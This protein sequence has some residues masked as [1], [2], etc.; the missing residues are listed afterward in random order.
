[1]PKLLNV[2]V[3]GFSGAKFNENVA[4]ALIAIALDVVEE[5]NEAD[6]Y[7]LVSGLTDM[8]VPAIAYRA[9]DKRG[10]KTVGIACSEANDYECYDVDE[11]IIEGE[12]WGDESKTFLDYIDVLVRIGGGKQSMEETEK[13]KE[14]GKSVYEYDLPEIK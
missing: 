5:N 14:M 2:G 6:E 7:A 13:A 1:M 10:W 11:K 9:A 4:K 8:G 3:V 12:K